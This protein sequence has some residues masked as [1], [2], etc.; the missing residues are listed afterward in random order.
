MSKMSLLHDAT[1]YDPFNTENF[2]WL[3][4]GITNTINYDLLINSNFFE[5]LS[6]YLDPFLFIRYTYPYYGKGVGEI[7][8]FD[9]EALNRYSGKVTEWICRGGLFGGK[10]D[11]VKQ[12]NSLYWHTL[13][14]SLNEGYMGTEESIFSILA[15]KHPHLFRSTKIGINGHIQEFVGNVLENQVELSPLPE[16]SSRF[17]DPYVNTRD[18][19]TSI[20]MLTFNFPH[21]VEHTIQT[22][23]KHQKWITNTRNI[24]IDNSTTEEARIANA[25]I[26]K[27]YNF[28][29]IITTLS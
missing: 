26:C 23:L 10:K 13:N 14:N 5:E 21:Q 4:A 7:H 1:I 24:L 11:A 8:G 6:K 27:K 2:I 25:E 9:W 22:W 28:E 3:D 19:K 16:K 20:Y 29:H 17:R 15:D 12:A 18:L